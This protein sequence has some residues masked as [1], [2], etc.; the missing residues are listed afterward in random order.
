MAADDE[1]IVVDNA[2]SDG[3][4][5]LV[6]EL[7]P[8]ATV[9]E[10]G[11]NLGYGEACNRG[12]HAAS[13][14]LL[15]FLNPDASPAVGW[16]DAIVAP[17]DDGSGLVAWQGLVT[18]QGGRV[19]NSWG[20]EVHF[21][22]IAWAGGA[23]EQLEGDDGEVLLVGEPGFVSGACLA[24][25]RLDFIDAG[26]FPPEF[27]LYHEDVDL[28]L[29]LRLRG[30]RLGVAEDAGVDHAY[31]FDKGPAKWRYLERNRW[32]TLIRTYPSPLLALLAPALVATELALIPISIAGGWFGQKVRAT[33]DVL[34][35]LGRLRSERREIHAAAQVSAGEFAAG[36]RAELDS[37]YLGAVGRSAL[38]RALLHAYWGV[39]VRVLRGGRRA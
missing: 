8:K 13:G 39:V 16:R 1:L 38:L 18:A 23:G 9:I 37:P 17:L 36:L 33:L 6:R 26:G 34:R 20:G 32:A 5:D 19:T 28:S 7:A 21:T 11:A 14:E 15:C 29:R 27:F 3:T 35:W 10:T 24:V 31:E 4:L 22:G 12:A 2:S 30:G 25:R